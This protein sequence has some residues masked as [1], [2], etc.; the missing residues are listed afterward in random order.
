MRLGGCADGGVLEL[1]ALPPGHGAG[2]VAR[3]GA[4]IQSNLGHGTAWV[5][6]DRRWGPAGA[7]AKKGGTWGTRIGAC[8][9]VARGTG[10]QNG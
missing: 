8:V 7:R 4:Q 6:V 2:W 1:G 3:I 9:E 5:H 10:R